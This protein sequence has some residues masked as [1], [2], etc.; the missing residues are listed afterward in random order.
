MPEAFDFAVS[1][2]NHGHIYGQVDALLGAG[3][4]L[5]AFYAPEDDLAGDVRQGLSAGAGGSADERA[6][7]DDPAVLLVVGAGIPGDRAPMALRAM[8]A[9]KDV[10]LDKPGC[11][12][13]GAARRAAA[14]A[15]RDRADLVD[16][17]FRALPA[18]GDRRRRRGWWRRARSAGWCN[19][20]GLGPHRVGNNPRPDW[21]WDTAPRRAILVDIASHQFEQFLYFTGSTRRG[22]CRASRPIST[23]P[24][25]RGGTTTATRW[26]RRTTRPASSASTG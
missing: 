22:S 5:K 26:W 11:T 21:F 10:M 3:C 1:G 15:G 6:I 25:S 9:G 19:T 24:S 14:G 23:I 18:E 17:L 12:T 2:I 4:R 8:R 16:L 20:I 13:R 7:L